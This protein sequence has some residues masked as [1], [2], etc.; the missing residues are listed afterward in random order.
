MQTKPT[1]EGPCSM[2]S[3]VGNALMSWTV[4]I[5]ERIAMLPVHQTATLSLVIFFVL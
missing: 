1:M 2:S 3:S 4:C 5:K